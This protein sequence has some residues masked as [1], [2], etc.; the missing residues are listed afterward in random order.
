[1]ISCQ[2][3]KHLPLAN[4]CLEAVRQL[5]EENKS[6]TLRTG[7]TVVSIA[8]LLFVSA[9]QLQ[10]GNF[11]APLALNFILPYA[12]T[13]VV[14]AITYGAA[15]LCLFGRKNVTSG[16]NETTPL[17]GITIQKHYGTMNATNQTQPLLDV[18]QPAVP[19]TV[20]LGPKHPT[21]N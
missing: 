6:S 7:V 10:L 9:A 3:K 15:R 14:S 11:K 21:I 2:K 18:V 4:T 16:N 19:A 1:M 17:N 13:P 8:Y 5:P 20:V 12:A